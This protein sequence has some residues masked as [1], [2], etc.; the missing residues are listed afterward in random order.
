MLLGRQ[1][2][3]RAIDEVLDSARSGVSSTLAL[4][5]EPGIGKSAL[6]E[7]AAE[8]AGGMQLLRVRGIESEA[9]IP[10]ASLLELVRPALE[11]LDRIPAP[12]AIAM[13]NALALRPGTAHER[14][15]VGAATLSLLA[16]HAEEAPVAILVDDAQWLDGSSANALLFALRRLLAD[17]IAVLMAVRQDERS[18]LDGSDLPTLEIGGL[19]AE[20]SALLLG[21]VS[22]ATAARLH[23]ATAGNPL[24]LLELGAEED[25]L[26]LAPAG[27]PLLV[28][29]RISRAFLRRTEGLQEASR[30]AL[31]LA[32]TSDSGEVLILERAAALVN[33]ELGALA[34]AEDAGLLGLHAGRLEFRHPLARSAIYASAPV[35]LRRE[36]HRALAAVLPDRDIDRRAWHLAAAA[37]GTDPSA[38]AAL[39]QAGA[40]AR[41]RS[42]YATATPAFERAARLTDDPDLRA[43]LLLDAA[44]TSWQ[45]GLAERAIALLEET[46]RLSPAEPILLEADELEG[47]IAVRRGPLVHGRDILAGAAERAGADQAVAMLA[48]AVNACFYAGRPAEMLAIAALARA[49][50]QAGAPER[51]RFLA[52]VAAG[53]AEVVG[54]DSAAGAAGIREAIGLAEAAPELQNDLQLLPWLAAAPIFLREAATGRALLARALAG[55]RSRSALGTLPLVLNLI[56]RDQA[57]T[58]Q[59]ALAE[60]SY[61]EAIQLAEESDQRTALAFAL[62]G[63]A[64]LQARRGR[65][66]EC[67]LY[68]EEALALSRATGAR[69]YEIWAVAALGELELGLGRPAAAATQF[70][71]Q[72]GLLAELGIT[73][74]DLSPGPDLVDAYVR[75][76]RD[77]DA[78]RVSGHFGAA[79]LTKGQPW[80]LARAHRCAGLLAGEGDIAAPFED[81]LGCHRRTPDAFESARTRL[82]YGERLRRGRNRVQAREQLRGALEL[83]E[84]LDARPWAQRVH[85]ELEASGETLRRRDPSTRDE[86]TPQELQ[87]GLLLAGGRT[88]RE[89]A[90]ALFLSPKTIEYHL[91]HV[92]QKLDIHSREELAAALAG[93]AGPGS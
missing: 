6:L 36:F 49:R 8:R 73:D 93:Q 54:G 44:E 83:F 27:A 31:V 28:S 40:R 5:G 92:Y 33:V 23:A 89:A 51:T 39:A 4:L 61:R 42:A 37:G 81:A 85:A 26:T 47:H 86:L 21:D 80:S 59:W 64:W 57:T 2:E 43:R 72:L 48:E 24:G 53:M 75:L 12:Q 13:E 74:P 14:F 7:D 3:Q 9:Q 82:A 32:A 87:I 84:R 1:R 76:G 17:P 46:R 35:E 10:F 45:A 55:A 19:D 11:A 18:L 15:A 66:E 62:S 20:T 38:S 91:R 88:T 90:S 52:T 22:A 58:E 34:A 79:A 70:E 65:E 50:L 16:A 63:L 71:R 77:E 56:A 29:S 67:R 30:R 69:L 25:E 78:Q 68:A 41:E 60:T